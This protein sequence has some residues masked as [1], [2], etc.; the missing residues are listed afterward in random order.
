MSR[1]FQLTIYYKTQQLEAFKKL[2]FLFNNFNERSRIN[3]V[4]V[5]A[6]CLRF[7]KINHKMVKVGRS[8]ILAQSAQLTQ[9][10]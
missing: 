3:R 10:A 2:N 6:H 5:E 7:I 8:L 9:S 4:P 1:E